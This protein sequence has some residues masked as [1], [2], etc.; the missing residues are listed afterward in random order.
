MDM[1]LTFEK[2]LARDRQPEASSV[3]LNLVA[4]SAR[5]MESASMHRLEA[6]LALGSLKMLDD[7][8]L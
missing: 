4:S 1:P 5:E 2:P 3:A 6:Y 8:P 7:Q